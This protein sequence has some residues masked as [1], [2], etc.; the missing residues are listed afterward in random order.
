MLR[1]ALTTACGVDV[2]QLA[3]ERHAAPYGAAK[4]AAVLAALRLLRA[5]LDRDAPLVAA[6][7]AATH[8]GEPIASSTDRQGLCA[9]AAATALFPRRL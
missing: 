4:E 8:A 2:D 3:Q 6:M 5:A 7:R 1:A 9:A